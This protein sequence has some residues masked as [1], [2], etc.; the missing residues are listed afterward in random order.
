MKENRIFGT[1]TGNA[2]TFC[3]IIL[4]YTTYLIFKQ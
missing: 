4:D 2:L 1:P 3:V